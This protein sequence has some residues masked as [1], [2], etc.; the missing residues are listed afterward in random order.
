[1]AQFFTVTDRR[2]YYPAILAQFLV[3]WGFLAATDA[4]AHHSATISQRSQA[5]SLNPENIPG[6]IILKGFEIIG[7]RV[8]PEAEIDSLLEPYL[9]RRISF[10]ELFEVQQVITQLFVERGYLTSGA[11]IPPQ[12]IQDRIVRVEI[13]EGSLEE[14][15]IY[16]LKHLRPGYVRERLA[17]ATQPPLNRQKLLNALQLLQLN[18]RIANISAE[19]SQGINP[20]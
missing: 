15:K 11:Y 18:P 9:L 16:G 5:P 3:C 14:I 6:T 4:N 13:I 7:N 1:M 19:L 8:I 17:A 12:K 10:V 2:I 20:G